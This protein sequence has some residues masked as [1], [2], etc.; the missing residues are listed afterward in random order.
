MNIQIEVIDITCNLTRES[1]FDSIWR[2]VNNSTKP[3]IR[4]SVR[5][6]VSDTV[7]DVVIDGVWHE[8]R[9]IILEHEYEITTI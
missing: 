6:S 1:F 4:S 8:T 9:N 3:R 2:F 7:W 5:H